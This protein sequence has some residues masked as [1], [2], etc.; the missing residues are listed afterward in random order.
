MA[1]GPSYR[2]DGF[3]PLG[4]SFLGPFLPLPL[5][6]L[7]LPPPE[8]TLV[9]SMLRACRR[10]A[11]ARASASR[12]GL[13]DP[14][15]SYRPVPDLRGPSLTRLVA[16]LCLALA[17]ATGVSM[18]LLWPGD[19]R[20]GQDGNAAP[21]YPAKVQAVAA[22]PCPAPGQS[23]CVRAQA[24]LDEG[25]D[26]GK[27][28]AF[29]I[30]GVG[31]N[32]LVDP[33]DRVLLTRNELPPDAPNAIEP[34]SLSGFERHTPLLL[35][36]G[37][38]V[39]I[40][41]LFA[42]GRGLLAL[43]GLAISLAIVA[44]FIVPAILEGKAPV[45][46]AIVGALGVMFVTISLAH[47]LGP[48]SM[49]AILGTAAS[50]GLIVLLSTL[51]AGAANLSGLASD[52]SA[53]LLVGREELSLHGLVLA[54]FIIGALGV[55]DDVTVSQASTVMALRRANP[56]LGVRRLYG[57]A[58]SVGRDHVA[59]TVNTLVLAYLGTSLPI[60]LLFSVAGTGFGEAVNAEAVAQEIV[61]T[62]VGSIGLVAAV[63]V[64]TVIAALLAVRLSQRQL[65]QVHAHAH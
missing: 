31:Q 9:V 10:G 57:E 17:A 64:T 52:Q 12:K 18:A 54:G 56:G 38:F 15:G 2:P 65:A 8:V 26:A 33:G 1:T 51:F 21:S 22:A 36:T 41:L 53:L 49:A 35:L 63:P 47:G 25:P 34:Y 4:G 5:P 61:G 11:L 6:G 32:E 42:R 28:V 29:A 48:Q 23:G 40:V 46:V 60:V 44:K 20:L 59:A 43:V 39:L 24:R 45:A 37:A 50:L 19:T 62:L 27:T 3:P 58:L 55:L 16:I 13:G 7:V 14:R 30:G